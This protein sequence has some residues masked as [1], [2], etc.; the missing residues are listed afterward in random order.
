MKVFIVVCSLLV[1]A[2]SAKPSSIIAQVPTFYTATAPFL[3]QYHS[4]DDLGQYAYGYNGGLSS[5]VETKTLDGV[6]RGA[7]SYV[8]AEN[9]LQTVEYTADA[10]NGF[11][12]AATNLPK[13]PIDTN[14]AP[15]AVRE[16]SEVAQARAEH[17]ALFKEVADRVESEPEQPIVAEV[18]TIE[19]IEPIAPIAT[20]RIAPITPLTHIAAPATYIAF[21]AGEHPATF[22]Y[23]FNTP[24]T[25]FAYTTAPFYSHLPIQHL[26]FGQPAI[27]AR[28]AVPLTFQPQ[29]LMPVSDTA[30]VAAAKVEH[31][32]AVEEQK[33]KI[34]AAEH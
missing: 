15:E 14:V 3:S 28:S 32:A 16:T 22:G 18:K 20:T 13:A 17:L 27:F 9:R 23:S 25:A 10:L 21:R 19:P 7:Y 24:N 6:T 8:D 1:V 31:L 26:A 4:Q 33:A 5:K 29:S 30:E 12:A 34:A 2:V 11:R